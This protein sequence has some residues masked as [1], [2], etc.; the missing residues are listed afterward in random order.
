[1]EQP[2]QKRRRA[3]PIASAVLDDGTII[4]TVF[5]PDRK[6]TAL[7]VWSG[8]EA[9]EEMTCEL[10]DGNRVAAYS[11][12]NNLLA[13]SV[14]LFPSHSQSYSSEKAL[15]A[16]IRQFI[17]RYVDVSEGFEEIATYYVLLSWIFDAFNEL[18]YLRL[19]GDF[20]SGKSRCLQVIGSICYKPIFASGA[21]TV[22]P[23]FRIIDIFR[24]TLVIDEG[25][26]RFSDERAEIVKILNNGNAK[27]FPVLRSEATPTKEF[28]PRAFTI[29]GPKI[30]ATRSAF[31]DRALE[32]RC[33][34][35]AMTG[36]PP[37]LDIPLS[38][39]ESFA[40]EATAL[41]NM[42][43]SYRFKNRGKV[44]EPSAPRHP[45]VEPRIAQVY[46]P[47]LAVADDQGA[48]GRILSLARKASDALQAERSSSV[49]AQLLDVIVEMR[50]EAVPLAIGEIARRFAER[51]GA[52]Y[53]RPVT[54][55]WVGAQL[56]RR[57]SLATTKSNGVFVVPHSEDKRLIELLTRYGLSAFDAET[58][59]AESPGDT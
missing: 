59:K 9:R 20:G 40:E 42:L 43:L 55:R 8:G 14:V 51:F 45:G 21:S 18:P 13:H 34:T 48:R 2:E 19:K 3:Q 39:P 22:S 10:P 49:E 58:A 27:G 54:P 57:L 50:R 35:E 26:F 44:R 6:Q 36:A 24:G 30:I 25:D 41:R 17:H 29:F 11:P 52:D 33:I 31:D 32:S 46:A 1:M 5:R 47:L 53:Y 7:L 37:R 38:L 16:A 28:N 23:L 4:E 12:D 15:V 56:H